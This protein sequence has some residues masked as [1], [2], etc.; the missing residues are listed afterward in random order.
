[1][2]QAGGLVW[3]A[4]PGCLAGLGTNDAASWV[5][6]AKVSN[7]ALFQRRALFEDRWQVA[8]FV[9]IVGAPRFC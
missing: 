2:L 3:I 9:R 4:R 6:Q 8:H 5:G 1:M 7:D